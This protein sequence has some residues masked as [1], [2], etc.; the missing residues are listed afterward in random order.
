MNSEISTERNGVD[1][2]N[3]HMTCIEKESFFIHHLQNA[4]GDKSIIKQ[5]QNL[6]DPYDVLY[7][8][9]SEGDYDYLSQ[10]CKNGQEYINAIKK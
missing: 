4:S 8:M 7:D 10:Y 1:T 6:L 5:A 2:H 3:L 9:V